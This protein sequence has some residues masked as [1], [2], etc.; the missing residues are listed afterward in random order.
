MS[1]TTWDYCDDFHISL[2]RSIGYSI[3]VSDSIRLDF[4]IARAT[5]HLIFFLLRLRMSRFKFSSFSACKTVLNMTLKSVALFSCFDVDG[6]CRTS[7]SA[8]RRLLNFCFALVSR[9]DKQHTE[10]LDDVGP[11]EPSGEHGWCLALGLE[12]RE[13]TTVG[14]WLL[15]FSP[16]FFR[17]LTLSSGCRNYDVTYHTSWPASLLSFAWW[18]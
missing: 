5:S 14:R 12:K 8:I 11:R 2:Y 10:R 13:R 1:C 18:L 3:V 6:Q 9:L 7:R 15:F 17:F 16:P 4:S